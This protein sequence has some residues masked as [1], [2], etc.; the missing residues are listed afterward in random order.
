METAVPLRRAFSGRLLPWLLAVPFLGLYLLTHHP[1]ISLPSASI[2]GQVAG[3]DGAWPYQ[4]PAFS[5]VTWVFRFL[6]L[7]ILPLAL[8]CLAAVF[9]AAVLAILARCALI[10]PRDRTREERLRLNPDNP[11]SLG[12]WTWA[13]PLLAVALIGL[14]RTFW[15]H[16]TAQTGELW[17][18]FLFA[19]CVLCLAEYRI[20]RQDRWLMRFA[21][22]YGV[23]LVDNW[24]F[25]GFAPLFGIALLWIRGITFF[26]LPFLLR[27]I[28][29]G[30]CGLSLYLLAP[31]VGFL[32]TGTW[33]PWSDSLYNHL[34][35]QKSTLLGIP[36]GRILLMGLID[37]LPLVM[38][39]I[40]WDPSKRPRIERWASVGTVVV[41]HVAGLAASI[42]M[43]LDLKFGARQ[44]VYL[45][46]ASGGTSVPLLTFHFCSALLAAY[47]SGYFVLIG[48][49]DPMRKWEQL[50][51]M[52]TR[53][54]QAGW[55]IAVAL[56]VVSLVFF[57]GKNW[58]AIQTENQPYLRQLALG[59]QEKL[60]AEGALILCE[61]SLL[62]QLLLAVD[63][64]ARSPHPNL[65]VQPGSMPDAGY[66]RRLARQAGMGDWPE[67]QTLA[68]ARTNIAGIFLGV[69]HRAVRENR[70]YL[71]TPQ[72]DFLTEGVQLEPVG[73]AFRAT[74]AATNGLSGVFV[75]PTN[76]P[77]IL[78]AWDH[79]WSQFTEST[80]DGTANSL[81]ARTTA[82]ILSRSAN[83]E[84]VGLQQ[85]QLLAP[86]RHLFEI[87]E[88]F[89]PG[90]VSAAVNLL[91]NTELQAGRPVGEKVRQP[92]EGLSPI[93]A[94][95]SYGPI[96]EP[97][98]LINLGREMMRTVPACMQ[99][100]TALFSRARELDPQ[101]TRAS[102]AYISALVNTLQP[103]RAYAELKTLL[104]R[105]GLG[106]ADR[107]SA[108]RFQTDV[109]QQLGRTDELEKL[110]V[111]AVRQ[112]PREPV[113]LDLLSRHYLE[114]RKL[115]Q[116]APVLDAWQ[117]LQPGDTNVQ[118]RRAL[119]LMLQEKPREAVVILDT[120]LAQDSD[121]DSAR[122]NRALAL[123]QLKQ[124]DKARS[125]FEEMLGKD[126]SNYIYH[127]GLAKICEQKQD[128]AGA[129]THWESYLIYAPRESADYTNAVEK[130][131]VLKKKG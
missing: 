11:E 75:S 73:L 88:K 94:F 114:R 91:A 39:G 35:H 107:I 100:A 93:G 49:F 21:L 78:S 90:N 121:M 86:S 3:L 126:P 74:P 52:L 9:G 70:A 5:L 28:G 95:Y 55:A 89:D 124:F 42:A 43:A 26:N 67:I 23:G 48:G 68:E 99:A 40:R 61:D 6:P 66:R 125:D 20:D 32:Q 113:P 131:R 47:F 36:R 24:A 69:W 109:L 98:T 80:R 53:L 1:W 27:F 106:Q 14:Q 96:E 82:Q 104:I 2:I 41:L 92:L 60:P 59:F 123:L 10:L 110:L 116:L 81:T 129:L 102:L 29:F 77:A 58:Q 57:T 37:L 45:D 103:Q 4:R 87:A 12:R 128:E 112:M 51:P 30:A 120:L 117:A 122:A 17:D 119:L 18:L 22:I 65:F 15:E 127:S 7:S 85:Q 16:A 44:L 25:Y 34:I 56:P 19:L 64:S 8:N 101:Y 118:L 108:L 38:L 115:S 79:R 62:H 130:V 50:P 83:I 105:P 72:L 63:R 54:T 111:D 33:V 76:A 84:G 31:L 71:V 97:D 46:P 13:P